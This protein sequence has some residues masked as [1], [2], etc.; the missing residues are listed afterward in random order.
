MNEQKKPDYTDILNTICCSW[1][2]K[3]AEVSLAEL[4]RERFAVNPFNPLLHPSYCERWVKS[5]AKELK[6]DYTYGGLFENRDAMWRGSYLH[7]DASVHLGIDVNV[8]AGTTIMCPTK[9]K[10]I[11]MFQDP[12][13]GGGWG[14]RI[15]VE[16]PNGL[17]IFSHLNLLP[18]K[19][20]EQYFQDT[21]LGT[22]A[23]PDTNGGWYPHLHLQGLE[24]VKQIG[25]LDG[26]GQNSLHNP[27]L[28]PD[29]LKILALGT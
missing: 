16:T 8:P 3:W 28:Y 22:V 2:K 14:G 5:I 26:Y 10:V 13:Q 11:E 1:N 4:A 29:P 23:E 18:F 20:G 6:V 9:F 27:R 21:A 17:V 15:L 19:L 24:S 7:S 12:D 25:D